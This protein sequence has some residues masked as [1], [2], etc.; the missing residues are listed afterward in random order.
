VSGSQADHFWHRAANRHGVP[1]FAAKQLM[2]LKFNLQQQFDL[3]AAVA[4]FLELGFAGPKLSVPAHG[5]E[6]LLCG[7]RIC[8]RSF[9]WLDLVSKLPFRA[10]SPP[11]EQFSTNSFAR[12]SF[13]AI[14]P[15]N[16]ASPVKAPVIIWLRFEERFDL[17]Q[18]VR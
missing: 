3:A 2:A 15:S 13:V 10:A 5:R 6:F 17:R 7:S 16:I 1:A 8:T 12:P 4:L 18:R 14:C 11:R 9:S